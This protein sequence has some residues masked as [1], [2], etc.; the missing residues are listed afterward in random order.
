MITLTHRLAAFLLI[1]VSFAA[2]AD[3]QF[4]TFTYQGQLQ[5]N[6]QPANG[7]F[8]AS[9][10]LFDAETSGNQ[11]S[12]TETLSITVT[13]G[14]FSA[15]LTYP[16]AFNGKQ[17]WLEITINGQVLSGRQL[18]TTAPVAQ[19][20]L[21]GGTSLYYSAAASTA[22]SPPVTV[23]ATVGPVTYKASCGLSA[24][25]AV[26]VSL[27]VSSTVAF[28]LS[29]VIA[30]RNNDT[31]ALSSGPAQGTGL[32]G[33]L[34]DSDVVPSGSFGRV[35]VSPSIMHV[36]SDPAMGQSIQA[37]LV[38]DARTNKRVCLVEGFVTAGY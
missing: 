8:P 34:I 10:A 1:A 38:A 31:G 26:T 22:A 37:Y 24:T 32:L 6:G 19:Y 30:G 2:S 29:E 15:L 21:N 12:F 9:F 28:D 20:A 14:A 13:N 25:N 17:L 11:V 36:Y 33:A 16:G 35:W 18:I 23:L 4:P 7:E 3:Q 5:L 27:T